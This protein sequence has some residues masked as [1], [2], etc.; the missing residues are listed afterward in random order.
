G[1]F[2]DRSFDTFPTEFLHVD[3]NAYIWGIYA[4]PWNWA[5]LVEP[6]T[7]TNDYMARVYD[8]LMSHGATFDDMFRRGR[9][10]VSINATDITNG[11][12][13]PFLGTDF[14]LLCSDLESYPVASAVAASNGF[15][16]LFSPVNLKSYA[17]QCGGLRPPLAAAPSITPPESPTA[18]A[19]RREL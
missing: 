8:R 3:I 5:W 11:A 15:P 12:T 19:R 2:R 7:G 10:I 18:A 13:F 16:G 17:E 9:P 14:G 1:L 6:A 4:L